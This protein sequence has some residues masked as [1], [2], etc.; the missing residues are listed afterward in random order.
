MTKNRKRT[1]VIFIA[2]VAIYAA[3]SLA[4]TVVSFLEVL[5]PKLAA[6]L[7]KAM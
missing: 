5:Q 7:N 3:L 6:P 1:I 2:I 4:T